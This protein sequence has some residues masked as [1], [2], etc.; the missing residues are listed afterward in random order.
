MTIVP[1]CWSP[2]QRQSQEELRARLGVGGKLDT[3]SRPAYDQ[4]IRIHRQIS[5][6]QAVSQVMI[7]AIFGVLALFAL[8]FA[9]LSFKTWPLFH[10]LVFFFVFMASIVFAAGGSSVRTLRN[11]RRHSNA[12]TEIAANANVN[13]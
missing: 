1:M 5:S 4:I 9:Y 13:R 6:L 8:F 2:L 3:L 7:W 12:M 10:V 11:A